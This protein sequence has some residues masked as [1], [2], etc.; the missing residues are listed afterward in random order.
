MTKLDINDIDKKLQKNGWTF[1]GP[2][3]G[4]EKAF[5]KQASVYEKNEKYIVAGIDKTGEK[6]FQES[7]SK[8]D[9]QK[10]TKESIIKISKFM[11]TNSE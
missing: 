1:I 4:Y 7:I 3:L 11:L 6:E 10:R 8:E 2:I 5:K 9:A